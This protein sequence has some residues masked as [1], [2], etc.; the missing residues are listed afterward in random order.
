MNR[1]ATIRT[2]QSIISN[3]RQKLYGKAEDNFKNIAARWTQLLGIEIK[4]WHVGVMMADVKLARLCNG[5]HPDGFVDGIGYLALAS[6]LSSDELEMRAI[7]EGST[8]L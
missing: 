2:A 6:E 1:D 8:A 5:P 7:D 3:H 4:P